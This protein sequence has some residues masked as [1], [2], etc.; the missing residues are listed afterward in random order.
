M[1]A[2][3][4]CIFYIINILTVLYDFRHFAHWVTKKDIEKIT[5]W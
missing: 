5:K 4:L 1:N 2:A 3:L